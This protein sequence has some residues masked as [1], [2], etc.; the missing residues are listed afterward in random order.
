MS[1][2]KAVMLDVA[3]LEV[4]MYV[5]A[6]D[7]PWL[8]TP[9]L[10]Q[11]FFIS[12]RDD[13]DELARYC[14]YVYV[15]PGRRR[16][17]DPIRSIAATPLR[18]V[19]APAARREA[20]PSGVPKFVPR[21]SSIGAALFPHRKLRRYQDQ[22]DLQQE[23]AR[24]RQACA[25]LESTMRGIEQAYARSQT[26][27]LDGINET[28]RPLIDSM[29]RN[30]EACIWLAGM[31]SEQS[32]THR[33]AVCCAIW[34]VAL[35]RQL[36]LPAL[37][38]HKLAVGALLFDI[39]K[40]RLP[41]GLLEK[42]ERLTRGEFELV[43]SHVL[44]GIEMMQEAGISTRSTLEM[45]ESHHE[46]HGGHGYPRGLQGEEIP[47]F[48]RIAAIVDCYDAITSAR[49]Y[50]KALSPSAAVQKMYAWRDIDFQ[51]ELVEEFIQ[52]VG[53]YPA[54]T[55]VELSSGEVAV[56]FAGYRTRRLRPQ[57]LLVLDAAKRRLPEPRLLDLSEHTQTADGRPL[58]I[59]ASLE[60]GA[61]GIGD[62]ALGI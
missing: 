27:Q 51:A 25:D 20:P 1:E 31:P 40:L 10:V 47:V 37:D 24:A 12:S 55:L 28:V 57:V 22:H 41:V 14:R 46:R 56:V 36:G 59:A 3:D 11:G 26:L 48:A 8:E 17:G 52:A 19:A 60:P 53:L 43:R 54:G 62:Q 7:R 6:L 42:R 34:A 18:S 49:P 13:V 30:P 4:G 16:P 61:Y 39:G 45:V 58:N 38:L 29:L 21:S 15:D 5:S 9:F 35:G 2:I 32:Y 50:V 33:H 44:F 23:L